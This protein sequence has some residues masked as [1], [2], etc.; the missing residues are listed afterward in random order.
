M[1]APTEQEQL[2]AFQDQVLALVQARKSSFYLSGR[3]AACRGYLNHRLTYEMLFAC[4]DAHEFGQWSEQLAADLLNH[5]GWRAEIHA[6]E[7]LRL[8]LSLTQ[9]R[10]MLL[11]SFL[12]DGA[13]HLGSVREHPQLGRLDSPE[14]ICTQAI[15]SLI[16]CPEPGD[17][18]DLVGLCVRFNLPLN[19]LL[20]QPQS[21]AAGVFPPELARVLYAAGKPEWERVRWILRPPQ[22]VYLNELTRL[23]ER[24][25]KL[26][27]QTLKQVTVRKVL[28][29]PRQLVIKPPPANLP[30]SGP[31][32][33]ANDPAVQPGAGIAPAGNPPSQADLPGPAAPAPEGPTY[34]PLRSPFLPPLPEDA[35]RTPDRRASSPSKSSSSSRTSKPWS[36]TVVTNPIRQPRI[37]S[38]P[39]P[40]EQPVD[41]ANP[42][43]VTPRVSPGEKRSE[44]R[45][46]VSYYVPVFDLAEGQAIGY[47]SD[48]SRSGMCLDCKS[49]LERGRRYQL[50]IDLMADLGPRTA[51][52]FSAEVRWSRVDPTDPNAYNAGL[53]VISIGTEDARSFLQILEK[54]ST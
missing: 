15:L 9:E 45:R 34:P 23:A 36:P 32:L 13:P 25:L 4:N 37:P 16:S 47:L 1:N 24:L 17:L 3:A 53:E 31:H 44:P 42:R 28:E 30:V 54:Y 5:A 39:E 6:R 7:P 49:L 11:V 35:E 2:Y 41:E 18:A 33:A 8:V 51:I 38:T 40:D 22:E 29:G 12:N 46:R 27:T 48:I 43:K 19:N 20:T 21:R 50:R 26:D 10:Q 14:N 52:T